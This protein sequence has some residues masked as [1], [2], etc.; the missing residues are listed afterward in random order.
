MA[1]QDPIIF[2]SEA[3]V[4]ARLA[5]AADAPP[6]PLYEPVVAFAS[7][8]WYGQR[9]ALNRYVGLKDARTRLHGR[10]QHGWQT[11]CGF[12]GEQGRKPEVLALRCPAF[13]WARHNL[14]HA[15]EEG[16][17]WAQAIGSPFF[18]LDWPEDPATFAPLGTGLLVFPYHS[19]PSDAYVVDGWAEWARKL[20][21]FAT[22]IG[23]DRTQ[24]P[25]TVCFHPL[26]WHQRR[27]LSGLEIQATCIGSVHCPDYLQ[28]CAWLIGRHAMVLSDRVCTAGFYAM[29]LGREWMVGGPK[30]YSV[31]LAPNEDLYADRRWIRRR[32]PGLLRGAAHR[33]VAAEQLGLE[34][35]RSRE[36]LRA[37]MYGWLPDEAFAA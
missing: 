30:L 37:L 35:K 31:P 9:H 19:A 36:D 7:N 29:W 24:A 23:F 3:D 17:D 1:S 28:R 5:V 16:M 25:V 8:D 20:R 21:K 2:P 34:F 13:V 18:Y 14:K 4:E 6:S 27:C 12:E 33:G 32:F 10:V 15:H 26:D 11:C 22:A